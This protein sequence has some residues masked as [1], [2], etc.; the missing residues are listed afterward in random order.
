MMRWLGLAAVAVLLAAAAPAAH[1]ADDLAW[2]AGTW[3]QEKDG[4]WTEERWGRPRGGMMLG[5]GLS[6]KGDT[7]TAFE[8]M[9]IAPDG[10]GRL[11][12]WGSPGGKPPVPFPLVALEG[13]QA[14]F[15]N[16]AHDFPTRITYRRDGDVLIAT[17]SGP[18]GK[19]AESWS[20]ALKEE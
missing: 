6:G 13:K 8:Y 15:E 1:E 18:D 2:L 11:A 16:P 9:R 5:T 12:F 17:V 14:R 4:R 7:A 10:E 19:D 20:Y 3:V